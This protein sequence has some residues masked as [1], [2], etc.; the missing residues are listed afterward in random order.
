MGKRQRAE[1]RGQEADG[2]K[3]E[4]RGQRAGGRWEKGRGQRAGGRWERK[5]LVL[6]CFSRSIRSN[7]L[8]YSYRS[9]AF[10][11]LGRSFLLSP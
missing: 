4:G 11:L 10:R 3:A 8:D 9:Q 7:S 1:G 6:G 2:K 5:G